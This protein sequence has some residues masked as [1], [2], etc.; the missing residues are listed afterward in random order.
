[1]SQ[2]PEAV[3]AQLRPH[4]RSM[5]W[6]TVLL[7][8]IAGAYGFFG[9][10]L[11]EEWQQVAA[12]SAAALLALVVWLVP[13]WRWA[14]HRYTITTQRVIVRSGI[15]VR[16]RQE[17]AL[18]VCHDVTLRRTALQSI[19]RSGDL[20]LNTGGEHPLVLV[21]VPSAGLVQA[22]LHDLISDRVASRLAV[23]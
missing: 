11:R 23:D 12:A 1:M 4:L 10:G 8:A 20:S 19:F 18:A 16:S 17:L 3:V 9:G 13:L 6:P 21:D 5:F 7:L 14:S 15:L 22:A 2:H